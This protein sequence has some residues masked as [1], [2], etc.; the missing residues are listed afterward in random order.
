MNILKTEHFRHFSKRRARGKPRINLYPLLGI[1]LVILAAVIGY[2]AM[3]LLL[4]A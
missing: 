1:L 4:S 3:Y 2:G